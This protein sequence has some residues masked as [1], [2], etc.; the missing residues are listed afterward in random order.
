MSLDPFDILIDIERKC[1]TYAKPLPRE[2]STGR[3]WQGIGFITSD[4]H[5]V[6]PLSEVV[7]VLPLPDIS[8]LLGSADWFKGVANLRGHL[9]PV[10]DLQ[11]FILERPLEITP[12]SRV[13]VVDIEQTVVGFLVSEVLGVQRFFESDLKPLLDENIDRAF[14]P[15]LQGEFTVEQKVWQILSLKG[16]SQTTRFYH[17]IKEMGV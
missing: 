10:T 14:V 11:A 12:K 3:I 17:V 5:F 13:L 1:R 9:L 15:F 2:K 4:I 7:E 6:A 8:M 16:L